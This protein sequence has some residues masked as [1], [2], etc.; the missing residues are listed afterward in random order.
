MVKVRSLC[1]NRM[2]GGCCDIDESRRH[3]INFNWECYWIPLQKCQEM[4][5]NKPGI[6]P[7]QSTVQQM[8]NPRQTQNQDHRHHLFFE[9]ANDNL[10]NVSAT[11]HHPLCHLLR[12][13]SELVPFASDCESY[14]PPVAANR[15]PCRH[16]CLWYYKINCW[17][18][19]R[20]RVRCATAYLTSAPA[21]SRLDTTYSR[22]SGSFS[23]KARCK[24]VA[25]S[26][27]LIGSTSQSSWLKICSSTSVEP[28][29]AL[30]DSHMC[31]YGV[32]RRPMLTHNG[33]LA[34]RYGF[35]SEYSSKLY[36]YE[37]WRYLYFQL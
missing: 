10:R 6:I 23:F 37:L 26:K 2:C 15:R 35:T 19:L 1:I 13:Y 18:M 16:S 29:D 33:E 11:H 22:S 28:S 20:Q 5:S 27:R 31:I 32:E 8:S 12:R 14:H 3:C 25:P 7:P 34:I 30:E 4:I 17:T 9:S 21:S 24:G 36:A